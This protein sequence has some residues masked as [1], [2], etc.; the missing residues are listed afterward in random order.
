MA[1]VAPGSAN[2][3]V[4]TFSEATGLVQVEFSRNPASFAVNQYAKLVPVSKDTGYYLKIDEEEHARVVS[5][6][7]WVWGDGNDAPEGIQQDNEFTAFRTQRHEPTL[8]LGQ[9]SVQ[10]ADFEVVAGEGIELNFYS[11]VYIPFM[12]WYNAEQLKFNF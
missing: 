7:D 12:M 3:Y 10:N 4:P 5:T 1:E 8:Q 6:S 11:D 2:T 9:K